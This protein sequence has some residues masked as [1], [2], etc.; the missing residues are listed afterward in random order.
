MPEQA[1]DTL[2]AI[3]DG[4]PYAARKDGSTFGNRESRLPRRPNGYYREYTVLTPGS[5]DR[6]ARRIVAG[7][8]KTDPEQV[9]YTGDHYDS[10]C[11]ISR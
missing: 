5:S 3:E 8:P 4:G 10:F 9:F 6:G 1:A 7:G 11:Q 2:E